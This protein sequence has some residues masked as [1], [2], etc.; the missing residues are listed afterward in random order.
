MKRTLLFNCASISLLMLFFAVISSKPRSIAFGVITDVSHD[1]NFDAQLSKNK[2]AGRLQLSKDYGKLPMYF[3]SNHGQVDKQVRFVSR[4]HGYTVYLNPTTAVFELTN[5]F[6]LES[7]HVQPI[8]RAEFCMKLLGA[9]PSPGMIGLEELL[10]KS[11]Y[12]LGNDPK[13]WQTAIPTYAKVK[14]ENVYAG[15]DLIYYGDL[16]EL[17]YD[18]VVAPHA[19]P[20]II[21]IVFEGADKFKID[22]AGNLVIYTVA[23][24][25]RQR[26]PFIYQIRKD[27]KEPIAGGFVLKDKNQIDFQVGNYDGN[28]PLF[29]DPVLS[30]SSYLGGSGLDE[31]FSIAVDE[32]GNAYVTGKTV[33]TDFQISNAIQSSNRGGFDI[34]VAKYDAKGTLLYSTYFGGAENDGG[35]DIAID[36]ANNVYLTGFTFS[37]DFPTM[38]PYQKNHAGS[39]DAF[40]VKLNSTGSSIVYSTYLGGRGFEEGRGIGVDA[41]RSVYLAGITFS[42]NF[43]TLNPIQNFLRFGS[44]VFVAKLNTAGNALAYSTYLG[45]IEN[46]EAYD[47]AIDQS[48][49]NAYVTGMASAGF[50]GSFRGYFP[51]NSGNGDAFVTKLNPA[52]TDIV[53]TA[54]IG[55]GKTDI[56]R[57]LVVDK[58]GNAFVTG[59]SASTDFSTETPL[60]SSNDGET[61]VFVTKL[62]TSGSILLFSTYLGGRN[63]DEGHGIAVDR[64]GSIY[65]TGLTTSIDFDTVKAIQRNLG[66]LCDAFVT[67]FNDKGTLLNYSTYLGGS[68]EDE[69]RGIAVDAS[70]NAYL[71]GVTKSDNFPKASHRKGQEDAF[72]AKISDPT[73]S[74]QEATNGILGAYA[75]SQ[76]YPNPFN[77]TTTIEFA[78][79]RSSHAML[80]IFNLLGEE[81]VTLVNHELAAGRYKVQWDASGMES[82]VYF[83]RLETKAFVQTKKLILMK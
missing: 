79:P 58:S 45:G 23:G 78:L 69:G 51:D 71:T 22:D 6:D 28:I 80:K 15:I 8:R 7:H 14:C 34:F 70:A 37:N 40:I 10:G 81:I 57:S 11:N 54:I 50:P 31:A 76:N 5:L 4:S 59:S 74:V 63:R 2:T 55:G 21:S 25:V 35:L 68:D 46:D 53:Y 44:D 60:Q 36:V 66:G 41:A 13:K 47:I 39:G 38:Q 83:Y 62:N 19:D 72:V 18:F 82:G 26:K 56:G 12:F 67:K 61:D 16:D 42:D 3:E 52:G 77:P 43:P 75:L 32:S 1:P 30:F 17:E 65:V 29:I 33:S 49:G 48:S 27:K 64:L 24:E 73:T 9:N 20:K